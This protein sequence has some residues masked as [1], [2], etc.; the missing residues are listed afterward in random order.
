MVT[1]IF[2]SKAEVIS[3]V[4]NLGIEEAILLGNLWLEIKNKVTALEQNEILVAAEIDKQR[5]VLERENEILTAK[6]NDIKALEDSI[7]VKDALI[8]DKENEVKRWSNEIKKLQEDKE[9]E[10]NLSIE[11]IAQKD[12]A[13][14]QY[15]ISLQKKDEEINSM[16]LSYNLERQE[17]KLDKDRSIDDLRIRNSKQNEEN[18]RKIIELQR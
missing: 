10:R 9:N 3:F 16:R 5:A 15:T 11:Q 4:N 1:R 13:V 14:K 6:N 2:K 17:F 8:L 18:D 12:E 7:L